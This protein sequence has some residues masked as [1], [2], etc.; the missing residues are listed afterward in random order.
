MNHLVEG[1]LFSTSPD[2]ITFNNIISESQTRTEIRRWTSLWP[3]RFLTIRKMTCNSC[4]NEKEDRLERHEMLSLIRQPHSQGS[5]LFFYFLKQADYND[6]NKTYN[7][8][9]VTQISSQYSSLYKDDFNEKQ[10]W[11]YH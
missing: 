9:R 8:F 1:E 11:S 10:T 2:E 6:I 7:S 5:V 4:K 3:H